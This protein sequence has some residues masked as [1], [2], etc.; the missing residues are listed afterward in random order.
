M[1]EAIRRIGALDGLRGVAALVVLIH[2]SFASIEPLG[3]VYFGGSA[4][5]G[6]GWLVNSPLHLIWAGPEAVYVFFILSGLVLTLP[7]LRRRYD[8]KSYYPSRLVRL[9]VPV[10][11]AVVFAAVC[12]LAVPRSLNSG[13]GAW[14]EQQEQVLSVTSLLRNMTLVSPDALDMPLWSLRWEVVFSMLLPLY[15]FVAL[16]MGRWWFL[17]VIA[18]IA[19]STFGA[20]TGH[21][22][23]LEFLP[24]FMIGCALAAPLQRESKVPG[25]LWPYLLGAGLL[26]ISAPW[27]LGSVAP[28]AAET[29]RPIVL[30]SALVIVVSVIRWPAA[31][32]L[33]E[34]RPARWLGRVSF[35]LYLTHAPI[36]VAVNALLPQDLSWL[37]PVIAIPLALAVAAVFFRLAEAPAHRLAKRVRTFFERQRR[38]EQELP[39]A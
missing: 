9:Y 2:H 33:F 22:A 11:A 14:M 5:A 20:L 12:V 27:W 4:P 1:G 19:L 28:S 6:L 39:A 30:A 31:G 35:S 13:R 23:V 32:R 8:W 3:D 25:V 36:V 18:A 21:E 26:G 15:V 34:T 24:M 29:T 7:A 16:R 17:L 10:I 38:P 37:T